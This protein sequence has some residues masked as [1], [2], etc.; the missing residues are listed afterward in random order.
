MALI[1]ASLAFA[2]LLK[3]DRRDVPWIVVGAVVAILASRLGTRLVGPELGPFFGSFG[4]AVAGSA[5]ASRTLRPASVVV[6]PGVL[7][8][9]PGSVGFRSITACWTTGLSP[10]STRRSARCSPRWRWWWDS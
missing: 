1:A 5:F 10:G 4:V 2:V 3:A 7:V 6:A 8:L 9:V